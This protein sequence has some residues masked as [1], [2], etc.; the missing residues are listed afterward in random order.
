MIVGCPKCKAKLKIAD[1]KIKPEGTKIKCPKCQ[2]VLLVKRPVKKAAPPP[3]PPP[4]AEAPAPPEMPEPQMEAPAP[5]SKKELWPELPP[6]APAEKEPWPE[7][8]TEAP[9]EQ[10]P[11]PEIPPDEL[12]PP[13]PEAPAPPE[14]PAAPAPPVEEPAA[15]APPVEEPA[16][17]A[18]P[19]E[20]TPF[21]EPAPEPPFEEPMAP[22]EEP[23]APA[24]PFEEPEAPAP[25]FEEPEAPA[26]PFEEPAPEPPFEEPVAPPA[27]EPVMEEPVAPAGGQKVLLAHS[28]PETV[29]MLKFILSGAN[30]SVTSASDG[31]AAMIKAMKEVPEVVV[32]DVR[33]PK[34]HGVEIMKRLRT[35]N[36]TKDVKVILTGTK[37]EA[38]VTALH[39]A[40]GYIHQDRM[41]QGLVE[42]INNALA[43]KKEEPP[44]AAAPPQPAAAPKPT[45]SSLLPKSSGD[46]GVDRAQR[47]SR[48]VMADI[49]LYNKEQVA[50]A[51]QQGTFE[52]AFGKELNEGL[53]LYEMRIPADVRN[54][55]D[56]Y[57]DA[58]RTFIEKK[59]N[60]LGL[61]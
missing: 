31:V 3:P 54:K 47:L 57:N 49:D 53:K 13:P 26:S 44:A 50:Q 61:S 23:E 1:E 36:E 52:S 29:N 2:A 32:A 18:P 43:A 21:E 59:K 17:P 41:Q 48:T 9:S 58:L 25:P 56:F 39:G 34:I 24:P 27:M 4:A 51:I 46:P 10:A 35:K 37:P 7:M 11:W 55:G 6:E 8:P 60:L 19:F 16:A 45:P 12:E 38:E 40:A 30:F 22:F 14:E 28:N 15:P 42:M 5:P 20:E 33:L